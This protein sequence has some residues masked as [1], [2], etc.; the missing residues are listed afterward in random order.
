MQCSLPSGLPHFCSSGKMFFSFFLLLMRHP[1]KTAPLTLFS[2]PSLPPHP[3]CHSNSAVSSRAKTTRKL[4]M[5]SLTRRQVI[6]TPRASLWAISRDLIWG[7]TLKRSDGN[8]IGSL[9]LLPCVKYS[10]PNTRVEVRDTFLPSDPSVC[11][12]LLWSL[13]YCLIPRS[14]SSYNCMPVSPLGKLCFC[15]EMDKW[16]GN[17]PIFVSW[18][19]EGL[20]LRPDTPEGTF[21]SSLAKKKKIKQK[22]SFDSFWKGGPKAGK[23][24][25]SQVTFCMCCH[26]KFRPFWPK[27][28][29]AV[30]QNC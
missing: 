30:G 26:S 1:Q 3:C 15:Y 18:C 12:T 23:V 22:I 28:V 10:M 17:L 2:F 27:S 7:I 8:V 6:N 29:S 14:V 11:S 24:T 9:E 20:C 5:K 25:V 4:T 21:P 19:C 16:S 13:T